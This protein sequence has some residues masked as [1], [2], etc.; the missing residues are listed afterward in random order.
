ME[1]SGPDGAR[2]KLVVRQYGDGDREAATRMVRDEYRLLEIL[3][4][5]ELAVPAPVYLD[6]EGEFLAEPA[7]VME[8]LAGDTD[9][10]PH[11][12][13]DYLV[14]MARHLCRI[15]KLDCASHNFSFLPSSSDHV[16]RLIA[17]R[18]G[19]VTPETLPYLDDILVVL[20]K[21]WPPAQ[22]NP[23]VLL[24]GDFWPGNIICQDGRIT[25]IIDW[26]AAKTGDPLADLAVSRTEVLWAFG[27]GAREQFTDHYVRDAKLNLG[28]LPYWDLY[29]ALRHVNAFAGWAA[30]HPNEK[31]MRDG[32][33]CLVDQVLRQ[34]Q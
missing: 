22:Q 4:A 12:L 2:H 19:K 15:H 7:M 5:Q 13:S 32:L 18:G 28:A 11:D 17:A 6:A 30:G 29:T 34:V 20:E 9:F 10:A 8:F 24:H 33:H 25:G 27:Q 21:A 26:E 23:D 3:T 14:Q 16:A 1:I 31:S